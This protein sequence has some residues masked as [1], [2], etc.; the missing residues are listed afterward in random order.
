LI[1]KG[2]DV[3]ELQQEAIFWRE[4]I[5]QEGERDSVCNLVIEMGSPQQRLSDLHHSFAEAM[6]RLKNPGT[7]SLSSDTIQAKEGIDLQKFEHAELEKY[8]KFGM[9]SN[10]NEFFE[11]HLLPIC[12]TAL[13]SKLVMQYIF[14]DVILTVAQFVSDLGDQD[15]Q[16][17]PEIQDSES[18]LQHIT[19]IEEM[20]GELRRIISGALVFRNSQAN[21]ERSILIQQA[22][23][24]IDNNFDDPDL[25]MNKIAAQY[26]L[27]SN[28]FSTVFSQEI[29]EPF[30]DYLNN[31]RINRAKELLSTTSIMCSQV[32]YQCG[33]NDAHYFSTFFKKKTGFTPQAFREHAQKN[34]G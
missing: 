1:I 7:A 27:S 26:N 22:K 11:A 17:A 28:H 5:Q 23:H 20:R 19:T 29:G 2:N 25:Q 15:H 12:E 18:W 6:V 10:F 4:L 16:I 32:A 31:L 13:Q 34:Q 9:L 3:E 14:L 8:L 30:R 33:Y 21:H 24:Y